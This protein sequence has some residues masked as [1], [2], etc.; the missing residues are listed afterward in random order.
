MTNYADF[1]RSN[2]PLIV[3]T[4]TGAKE[5]DENF[6]VYLDGLHANYDPKKN[7]S[8]VFDAT[9]AASPNLKYQQ[10]QAKWMK[11][12]EDLI[13]T[14]CLGV[15]YVM[16]NIVLRTVLK[17]IFAIQNN[18]VPFKVFGELEEGMAWAKGLQE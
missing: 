4:F 9:K 1:D 14:Y 10:R 16:P 11:E 5:T 8:L 13:Q 12:H 3:V 15:A 18:P 6:A 2:F 17:M 7:F